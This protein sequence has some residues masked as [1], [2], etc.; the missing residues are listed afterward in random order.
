MRRPI[1]LGV[2][3]GGLVTLLWFLFIVQPRRSEV[4][5]LGAQREAAVLEEERLLGEKAQLLEIQENELSY[6]TASAALE[7][8]IP[9]TPDLPTFIED[10]TLL[11]LDSSV[12]LQALS[13]SLPTAEPFAE[14]ATVDVL[15]EVEGQF[16]EVLG[17]LYGLADM[18]RL[19][20]VDALTLA[21]SVG[22]DRTVT[23][24][25]SIDATIFTTAIPVG[26]APPPP[27]EE[28]GADSGAGTEEGTGAEDTGGAE[29]G[30]GG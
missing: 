22:A 13:P 14:F 18:P 12:E 21:P 16:F 23:I 8:L 1:V 30:E 7:S 5:D 19:V 10:V 4:D 26:P 25:A 9:P 15:M 24:S 3:A 29:G 27:A 28:G 11:A 6:M 2:V 17:F 20:R